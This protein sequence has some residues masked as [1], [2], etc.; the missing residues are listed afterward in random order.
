MLHQIHSN[1]LPYSLDDV[2]TT[3]P[4]RSM[5]AHTSGGTP[6]A[7][8]SATLC[9][10]TRGCTPT[11]VRGG[12]PTAPSR[13][14]NRGAGAGSPG[15]CPRIAPRSR[16]CGDMLAVCI[17]STGVTHASTPWYTRRQCAC[18]QTRGVR[19]YLVVPRECGG[20]DA[21][22]G[23]VCGYIHLC[24]SGALVLVRGEVE[25]LDERLVEAWLDGANGHVSCV[26]RLVGIYQRVRGEGRGGP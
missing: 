17:A 16:L 21:A 7:L 5:R 6:N 2:S 19:A 13:P 12:A 3:S 23:G 25:T 26:A 20:K 15:P 4:S 8:S 11:A 9:P 22:Q 18:H 1:N 10:P 14:A 24:G